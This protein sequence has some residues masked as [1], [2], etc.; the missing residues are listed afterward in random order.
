M[1]DPVARIRMRAREFRLTAAAR[2]P[3]KRLHDAYHRARIEL[4]F[5]HEPQSERVSFQLVFAT[6]L[7][8]D[9]A[10]GKLRK[11][12]GVIAAAPADTDRTY[13]GGR[14]LLLSN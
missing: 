1:R 6:V 2:G 13:H 8:G 4:R 10:A 3:L 12:R 7:H 11:L 5:L 9:H 14:E